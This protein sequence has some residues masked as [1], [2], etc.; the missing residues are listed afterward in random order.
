MS[1]QVGTTF[2]MPMTETRTRGKVRHI[3]PLPSDSTMQIV[4][5]SA[6]PKLAPLIGH[7]RGQ[8]LLPQ[9]G[10]GRGGQGLRLVGQALGAFEPA[11]EELADLGPV[12]VD[13]RHEDVRR[14]LA[15]ELD[16]QLGQVGLDRLDAHMRERLVEAD[17]VGGQRLDLDHFLGPVAGGD[18]GDDRV[19]L[20]RV[21][22][23][24]DLPPCPLDRLL[25]LDQVVVEVPERP[26]LDRPAGLA[27]GLPVGQL[28]RRP[29]PACRGWSEWPSPCC[30]GAACRPGPAWP[31]PGTSCRAWSA[32]APSHATSTRHSLSAHGGSSAAHSRRRRSGRPRVRSRRG[33]R[34]GGSD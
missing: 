2:S 18:P 4:P 31:R 16:D 11:A 27:E 8:E 19:G 1:C 17:L 22:G 7:R 21:L 10:P 6:T 12:L 24:V 30:G 29:P 15:G 33:S 34:R 5:V 28:V 25:E 3:R 23:P 13:G 32:A 14:S 9:V 26:V 20:G